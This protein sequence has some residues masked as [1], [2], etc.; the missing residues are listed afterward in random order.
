[1]NQNFKYFDKKLLL[2]YAIIF[3]SSLCIGLLLPKF[4]NESFTSSLYQRIA[5]HFQVPVYGIT[6]T[7]EWFEVMLRYALSDIICLCTVLLFSFSAPKQI[8]SGTVLVYIGI[9][10]GCEASL[11]YFSYIA[12][13]EYSPSIAEICVFFMLKTLLI[14]LIVKYIIY[15]SLFYEYIRCDAHSK[16]ATVW[17]VSKYIVASLLYIFLLLFL[18]GIY[19]FTIKNL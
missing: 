10:N 5:F 12:K 2:H 15:T 3:I 17:K 14:A 1:M 8:V 9:K 11:V 6:K 7:S 18:H 13:L 19:I 16:N 4:L